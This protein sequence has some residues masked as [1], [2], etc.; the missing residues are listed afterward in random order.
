MGEACV[1][2]GSYNNNLSRVKSYPGV[3]TA[4]DFAACVIGEDVNTD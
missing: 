4:K 1:L 2:N 3:M